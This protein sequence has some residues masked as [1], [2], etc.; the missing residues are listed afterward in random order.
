M[1]V[2][3]GESSFEVDISSS[4]CSCNEFD[5]GHVKLA[6]GF[7]VHRA[8]PYRWKLISAMHKE[9]RRGSF[10][11]ALFYAKWLRTQIYDETVLSYLQKI[12]FEETRNVNLC[13]E[14]KSCSSYEEAL[15][16]IA[17]SVKKWNRP[18]GIDVFLNEA[19]AVF[20]GCNFPVD[21]AQDACPLSHESHLDALRHYWT[22]RWRDSD[23]SFRADYVDRLIS[24]MTKARARNIVEHAVKISDYEVMAILEIEYGMCEPS[25]DMYASESFDPSVDHENTLY[26]F[27]EYVDDLHTWHGKRL[28]KSQWKNIGPCK[29]MPSGLDMRFS[30]SILGSMW[31][32]AAWRQYGS[33]FID[34]KWHEVQISAIEWAYAKWYDSWWYKRLYVE[35]EA[36]VV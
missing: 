35:M 18:F 9:I 11:R 5:C 2:V 8:R 19:R 6:K 12:V 33:S 3:H 15:Y 34:K 24:K 29:E 1:L 25:S 32:H 28:I 27:E 7:A 26:M 16:L 36:V 20:E 30:G 13:K 14:I 4:S 10:K 17:S 23:R 22:Y 31:R 21:I